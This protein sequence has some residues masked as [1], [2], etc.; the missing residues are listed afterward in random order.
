MTASMK[1]FLTAL[2]TML[3]LSFQV[4]AQNNIYD[5]DDSC[6]KAYAAAENALGTSGFNTLHA[7]LLDAC[8]KTGDTK[9]L[10]LATLLKL[11]Q[12]IQIGDE[13]AIEV[14]F[15]ES[16]QVSSRTGYMQYYYFAYTKVATYYF[17]KHQVLK[18]LSI[19]SRMKE[20]A[21]RLGDIYGQWNCS[22]FLGTVNAEMYHFQDARNYLLESVAIYDNTSDPTVRR[23]PL[24]RT[25]IDLSDTYEYGSDSLMICLDRAIKESKTHLDTLRHAFYMARCSAVAKD[26]TAYRRYK[27]MCAGDEAFERVIPLS[28]TFFDMTDRAIA[29]DWHKVMDHCNYKT[30]YTLLK[31]ADA[32]AESYGA[33]GVSAEILKKMNLILEDGIQSSN[34]DVL[35]ELNVQY[36]TTRLSKE[37][38]DKTMKSNRL[39]RIVLLLILLLIACAIVFGVL[40]LRSVVKAKQAAEKANQMKVS[41]VQN[42][43]HEIRTPL[44]AIVGFSQLLSLPGG[45]LS[46]EERMQYSGFIENNSAML[47]MLIDDIL[48]LSDVDSGNYH[49]TIEKCN[50]NDI[51]HKAMNS[52]EYRVPEGVDFRF[53]TDLPGDFTIFSDARRIQQVL[54][55]YL[56]NSCKHTQE[57]YIHVSC[58]LEE[59]PGSVTFS[60]ADTGDGIDPENAEM[61]FRRFAKLDPFKQGSGLGLNI[62]TIVAEKLGGVVRLDK[63][64]GRCSGN[65][66]PGA[67]FQFIIPIDAKKPVRA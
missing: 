53:T 17:N 32:L 8:T 43:S 52:V 19:A 30:S 5:I 13:A 56:T 25:L 14:A 64:Y 35:A 49:V 31:Y 60:V 44:N 38:M 57:G 45:V 27:D 34:S 2:V 22:R 7:A 33:P 54:V 12:S 50:C 47:T 6:Y 67:R 39:L 55:N 62:C 63:T 23:Q 15:D 4:L 26:F 48:D 42:M 20:D 58:S 46:D 18:A 16:L 40:Y 10:T 66:T 11:S 61:I 24:A 21:D 65:G 3:V 1:H 37:L 28:G 59:N 9:A 51:C 36:E 41:F 29:G